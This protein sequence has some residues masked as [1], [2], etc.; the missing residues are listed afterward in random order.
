MWT[1]PSV[2]L[3]CLRNGTAARLQV[4]LNYGMPHLR[5]VPYTLQVNG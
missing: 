1:P 3:G 2:R 5:G 4:V